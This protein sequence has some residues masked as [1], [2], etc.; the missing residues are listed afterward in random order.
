MG[1]KDQEAVLTMSTAVVTFSH[2]VKSL[3]EGL[4]YDVHILIILIA[5]L[6]SRKVNELSD[7]FNSPDLSFIVRKHFTNIFIEGHFTSNVYTTLLRFL[8]FYLSIGRNV[9]HLVFVKSEFTL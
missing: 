8:W 6:V 2:Q 4:R 5:G 7:T 9:S 3:K 1:T